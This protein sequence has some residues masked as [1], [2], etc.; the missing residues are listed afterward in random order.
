MEFHR[1]TDLRSSDGHAVPAYA[2]LPSVVT[3][4]VAVAH[5]YGGCKEHM[6]GLAARLAEADLAACVFDI[7]GH[8]EHPAPLGPAMGLD[9][10]AALTSL[11]RH[12]RVAA[13]GHSLGGR[14]ALASSADVVAAI[15]PALPQKPSEEGRA[16]LRH[17]GSTGVRARDAGEIL[18]ILR[19]LPAPEARRRPTLLLHATGDIPSLIQAVKIAAGHL[20]GSEVR[21][22]SAQQHPAAEL[23]GSL[24]AYLPCWFNHVD[25]KTNPELYVELPAWLARHLPTRSV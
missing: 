15:S 3:G 7:R 22:I 1:L 19:G 5:G 9:L 16:M 25:L 8:G 10:E 14:L 17:F 24:L 6:L 21:V 23:P 2:F 12:G 18:D 4:G 20:P 11:R 13:V